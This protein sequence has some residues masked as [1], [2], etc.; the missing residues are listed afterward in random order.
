M[1]DHLASRQNVIHGADP[2]ELNALLEAVATNFGEDWLSR[3]VA[4][5]LQKL[6]QRR[7]ALATNELLLL[8]EAVRNLSRVDAAWTRRQIELMKSNDAGERAGATF[9]ILGLNLFHVPAAD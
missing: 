3:D 8:G 7:D 2:N 1:V 9:E 4:N 6:W 5:P